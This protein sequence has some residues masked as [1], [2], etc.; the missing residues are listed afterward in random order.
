MID[1]KERTSKSLVL[2]ERLLI[3]SLSYFK[4]IFNLI[5]STTLV[6]NKNRQIVFASNDFL[7][8][9]QLK[10]DGKILGLRAGEVVN[11]VNA[12][13]SLHGCSNSKFC[14]YCGALQAVLESQESNK[15]ITRESRITT[16]MGKNVFS[17]DL[18]VTSAPIK[19][20]G[21]DYFVVTMTDISSE[22]RKKQLERI[23]LHDLVNSVGGVAGSFGVL[24]EIED[25]ESKQKMLKLMANASQV[26]LSQVLSYRQLLSA[27]AGELVVE[28]QNINTF[29]VIEESI[30]IVANIDNM[31]SC[32]EMA[33]D[34]ENLMINTDENILSRVL[35]NMIKNAVEAENDKNSVVSV[36]VQRIE[37][38][39][40]FWVRNKKEMAQDI[41]AQVFQRS[42]STKGSGRGL[43]TYSM[44]LLGE[45]YL[46]GKV[47]FMSKQEE[48]TTFYIDLNL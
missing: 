6:L 33:K 40:R 22:N 45:K 26:M 36:G 31:S 8:M 19:I 11:C 35:V 37:D 16:V 18:S 39:V 1:L 17:L 32:I 10:S 4:D 25:E 42:F 44:K 27:E 12:S 46:D 41:M 24:G 13:K 30:A 29:Q 48:G 7:N 3:D 34:S 20:E 5:S 9:I 47:D 38:K 23:F 14:K 28:K 2:K 43:G 15:K 21:G